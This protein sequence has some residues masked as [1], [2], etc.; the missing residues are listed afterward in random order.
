[1]GL[2]LNRGGDLRRAT[3][4]DLEE[5][6]CFLP[7]FQRGEHHSTGIMIQQIVIVVKIAE[8]VVDLCDGDLEYR[9]GHLEVSRGNASLRV[10]EILRDS[11]VVF[12][13]P[14]AMKM[15]WI[16]VRCDGL[17]GKRETRYR[18]HTNGCLG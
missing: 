1:M 7:P 18:R 17:G 4:A 14:T 6:L 10:F 12:K 2:K 8:R 16:G 13:W 5:F 9:E 11:E 15:G 3:D